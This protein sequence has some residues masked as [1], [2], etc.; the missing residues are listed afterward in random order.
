MLKTKKQQQKVATVTGRHFFVPLFKTNYG[1]TS[2]KDNS[3]PSF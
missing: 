3:K 1:T 2:K